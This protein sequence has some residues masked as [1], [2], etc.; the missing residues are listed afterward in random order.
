MR[1]T[2]PYYHLT[3]EDHR[4]NPY[5]KFYP[6]QGIDGGENGIP[7]SKTCEIMGYPVTGASVCARQQPAETWKISRY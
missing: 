5:V 1:D 2:L 4:Y 6:I 7:L 3:T